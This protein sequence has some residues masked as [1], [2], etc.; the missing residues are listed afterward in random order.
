L[1]AFTRE[2]RSEGGG[3]KRGARAQKHLVLEPNRGREGAAR[4]IVALRLASLE[5]IGL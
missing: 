5:G 4:A 2:E 1:S 3:M